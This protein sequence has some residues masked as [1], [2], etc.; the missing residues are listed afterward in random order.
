[1]EKFSKQEKKEVSDQELVDAL[2]SKGIENPEAFQLLQSW[3]K[4]GEKNVAEANTPEATIE[5]NRKRA[6]LYIDAGYVQEGL[7]VLE[8]A[9]MQAHNERREELFSQIMTEM[10]EIEDRLGSESR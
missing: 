6:R 4:Q 7:E 10:D 1:M 9:R 3:I 8:G 5:F 2:K